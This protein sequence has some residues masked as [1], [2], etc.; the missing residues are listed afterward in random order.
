MY[1]ITITF[2]VNGQIISRNEKD[3]TLLSDSIDLIRARFNF[4]P[5]WQGYTKTAIFKSSTKRPYSKILVDDACM[6]P[7]EAIKKSKYMSV[8][9]FGVSGTQL[10]TAT[11]QIVPLTPSGYTD[12]SIISP[13]PTENI[14]QQIVTLMQ[15]QA[16][17]A[18]RAE[19]AQEEAEQAER[20]A[21]SHVEQT[22]EDRIATGED[23]VATGTDRLAVNT[24]LTGFAET[25]LPN[26]IQAVEDKAD[27]EIVHIGQAGDTQV[28]AVNA[29]GAERIAAATEQVDRVIDEARDVKVALDGSVDEASAINET[30][31]NP[32]TGTI[33]QASDKNTELEGTILEAET[34]KSDLNDP[35]TGAITLARE[36]EDDLTNPTTGAIKKAEDAGGDIEQ[37]II[38]NEIV[39]QTEF[40]AHKEDYT[41]Q[42]QQDQLKVAKVE[43]DINDYKSTIASV[44][45]NQE[46]KQKV[47]GYGTISL[48]KATA[49]GQVSVSVKGNTLNQL[50]DNGI[51]FEKWVNVSRASF[52]VNGVTYTSNGDTGT[53]FGAKIQGNLK[54]NTQ[55]TM[56]TYVEI[57]EATNNNQLAIIGGVGRVVDANLMNIRC[58]VGVNK[59]V[60]TTKS[61]CVITDALQLYYS[62]VYF[63]LGEKLKLKVAIFEG[64]QTTDPVVNQYLSYGTKSTI[65]ASRLKSVGKNLIYSVLKAV[66]VGS[67][68]SNIDDNSFKITNSSYQGK[69]WILKVIPNTIYYF[70]AKQKEYTSSGVYFMVKDNKTNTEIFMRN[71]DALSNLEYTVDIPVT[72]SEISLELR[73]GITATNKTFYDIVFSVDNAPYEPY[74]ESIAYLPNVGELRS[75]PNGTKDEIMVSENKLI[76]RI[77]EKTNVAS[78]AVINYA[79]MADNGTYYAR[80]DD[81][82]TETGVKGD[83]L[84]I[85]ATELTYQL[86]EPIITLI[87]V[88]GN[89]ISYPSGT[90]CVEN[91]VA[92]AGTYT[93]KFDIK[94]LQLPIKSIDKL[95]K[96]N[97]TTGVQT[98][99]DTS[100]AVINED[101]KSFTHPN[102]TDKDMVFVDYYYDV[103]STLG[104]TTIEY[105]D[106]R[107]TIKDTTNNK[108]YSWKIK[109]TNGV[110]T[111][112]LTEVL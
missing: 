112:E 66:N 75:L 82:E 78:G 85:D 7:P 86:A 54:A 34:V 44:N 64:D 10:I 97:F 98:V 88:S 110:P 94:E 101:N 63:T 81:G 91:V 105:L 58:H 55:Y 9:V 100:L 25:T 14:Y 50:L 95:I 17:D 21:K 59:Y 43:K 48:P 102:L 2:N 11:D 45:V 104:E 32:T 49:N 109:S 73:T 3:M 8:S 35:L 77:S 1:N 56:V 89:L 83:T 65:S 6:V 40:I 96:Y 61:D 28:Q 29:A 19:T 57:N 92:D 4:S 69:K 13:A 38:D 52:D 79:D 87:N 26:A 31:S 74:I 30:L 93:T 103:E 72:T 42:I 47:T 22:G 27:T 90:V 108:F 51:N 46:A 18:V 15:R 39:T 62:A 107:H 60:F 41:S 68:V 84:G 5:E 23:R 99:L 67:S 71:A 80:N 53:N 37:A 33:K 12:D 111:V 20:T 24:A 106:S 70:K 76:K 36:V 16:V